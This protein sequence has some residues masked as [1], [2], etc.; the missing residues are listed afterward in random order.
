[1]T[2]Q[3]TAPGALADVLGDRRWLVLTGAGVST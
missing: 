3:E 1:V 2:V